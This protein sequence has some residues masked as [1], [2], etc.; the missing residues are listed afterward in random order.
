[1]RYADGASAPGTTE[2]NALDAILLRLY[3]GASY[4]A[5]FPWFTYTHIGV[6]LTKFVYYP[7]DG[8]S[9]GAEIIHTQAGTKGTSTPQEVACCLTLRT[10]H[11]GRRY[12][13]RIFLP[14][15]DSASLLTNGEIDPIV[16]TGIQNQWIGMQTALATALWKPVVAS[17]G[18]GTNHG[19]P[20]TWT[21]FATD[22]TTVQMDKYAD[23]IRKRKS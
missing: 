13:G 19:S 18:H 14:A 15:C 21:P 2:I 22:I 20:T 7:L 17:Y 6:K 23:V 11:R 10:G 12:R 8:S 9:L 5:G 1:M 16:L 4:P 3:T